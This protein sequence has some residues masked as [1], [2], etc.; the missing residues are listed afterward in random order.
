MVFL[1]WIINYFVTI[2][3][4]RY[5]I[6]FGH[7]WKNN[8]VTN[9]CIINR[10]EQNH[11]H[12]LL[13]TATLDGFE[14]KL[15]DPIADFALLFFRTGRLT[16]DFVWPTMPLVRSDA[17]EF[18]NADELFRRGVWEILFEFEDSILILKRRL[19]NWWLAGF[20]LYRCVPVI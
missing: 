8:L 7:S 19:E 17:D 1:I 12:G 2:C 5:L 16:I 20:G 10:F 9:I 14:K 15:Y 3:I 18:S 13:W 6:H 11:F 4:I